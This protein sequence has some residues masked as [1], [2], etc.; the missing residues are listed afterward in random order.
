MVGL[1]GPRAARAADAEPPAE[2]D[3][4]SVTFSTGFEFFRGDYGE[5]DV[6]ESYSIPFGMTVDHGPWSLGITVPVRRA[7]V[8]AVV[9]EGETRFQNALCIVRPGV[10]L[11]GGLA[12]IEEQAEWGVGDVRLDGSATWVPVPLWAPVLTA[13]GGVSFPT[14]DVDAALGTGGF[15]V[16]LGADASWVVGPVLPFVSGGY[17]F[18]DDREDLGLEDYPFASLGASWE[19]VRPC[20][21][22]LSYDWRGPAAEGE[23]DGHE[24]SPSLWLRLGERWT[25][26]AFGVAGLSESAPDFGV[27]LGLRLRLP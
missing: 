7:E 24:L 22:S 19:V 17:V 1:A 23:G 20:G 25:V 26:E 12:R 21:L 14:G 15:D 2:P 27:G 10:A 4:G 13:F 18:A 6:S 5:L 16:T 3:P 9:C 11:D 8:D